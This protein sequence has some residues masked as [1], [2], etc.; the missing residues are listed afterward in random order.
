MSLCRQGAC[1]VDIS[2]MNN[3]PKHEARVSDKIPGK[4]FPFRVFYYAPG[5]GFDRGN[6]VYVGR[7]DFRFKDEADAAAVKWEASRN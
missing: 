2:M 7:S 6:L 3:E 1:A 5:M 4:A